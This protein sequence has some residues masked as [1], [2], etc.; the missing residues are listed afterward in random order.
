LTRG[1]TITGAIVG[2]G[3]PRRVSAVRWAIAGSIVIAGVVTLP[4]AA[5]IGAFSYLS[6]AAFP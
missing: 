5:L 2:V 1:H 4:A 3:A 6:R